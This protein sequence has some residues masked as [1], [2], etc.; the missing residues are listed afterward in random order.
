[1]LYSTAFIPGTRYARTK[2]PLSKICAVEDDAAPAS[3]RGERCDRVGRLIAVQRDGR[4]HD[5]ADDLAAVGGD[6]PDVRARP[7]AQTI[8]QTGLIGT[9]ERLGMHRAD[10]RDVGRALRSDLDGVHRRAT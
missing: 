2:A 4:E 6:E 7:L 9:S 5:V 3:Q 8:H 1:M 10:R